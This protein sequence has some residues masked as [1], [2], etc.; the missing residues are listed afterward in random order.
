MA[1]P[2]H[3]KIIS[4]TASVGLFLIGLRNV[5]K[6]H[7][8]IPF[9]PKFEKD[10]Y[11]FFWGTDKPE[12][13]VP[14]QKALCRTQGLQLMTLAAAK[15][16]VL[17]SNCEGT[18]LR[19]NLFA[20]FGFGQLA[21]MTVLMCGESQSAAKSAGASFLPFCVLLGGEGLVL[22]FDAFGRDRPVKNK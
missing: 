13:L 7:A 19:R 2:Q 12:E 11:T 20:T 4:G 1:P 6:P 18:F 17:F 22:L 9:F 10:L 8:K 3:V 16:T 15:L 5:I 21:G 14:G